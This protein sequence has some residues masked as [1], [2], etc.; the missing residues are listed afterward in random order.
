M[1]KIF[2]DLI[3]LLWGF[4]FLFFMNMNFVQA[5]VKKDVFKEKIQGNLSQTA[6]GFD[7]R[8]ITSG[9]DATQRLVLMIGD[10]IG[11]VLSLIGVIALG[12]VI[13]G[14]YL[15]ISSQGNAEKAAEARRIIVN[16]VIAVVIVGSSYLIVDYL[17]DIYRQSFVNE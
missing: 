8:S 3:V 17:L 6:A 13:Y 1:K 15:W 9:G 16:S 7:Q 5:Q 4:C 10:I 11:M 2:S 14:G 12:Y